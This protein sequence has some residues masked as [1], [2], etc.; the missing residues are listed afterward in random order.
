MQLQGSVGPKDVTATLAEAE[1][2]AMRDRQPN[3]QNFEHQV[4]ETGG[5]RFIFIQY[6][7]TGLE[8]A[9]ERGAVLDSCRRGDLPDHLHRTDGTTPNYQPTFAHVAASFKAPGA[10]LN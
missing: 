2:S 10:G 6:S 9:R 4:K 7:K 5:R 1:L 3:G 8:R